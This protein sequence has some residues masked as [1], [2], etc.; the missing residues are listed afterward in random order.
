MTPNWSLSFAPSP[1]P[2]GCVGDRERG[3]GEYLVGKAYYLSKEMESD[4]LLGDSC[5]GAAEKNPTSIH[6]DAGLTS[7]L[8]Q[9]V[10]DPV[11]L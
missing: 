9:C 8:T 7:G 1:Y 11:L 4:I 5:C 6:E 3:K 2:K 10:G